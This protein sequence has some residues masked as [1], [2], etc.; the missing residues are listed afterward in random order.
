MLMPSLRRLARALADADAGVASS[1]HA[2]STILPSLEEDHL[3][4]LDDVVMA[5]EAAL[6]GGLQSM[7]AR[8]AALQSVSARSAVHVSPPTCEGA[9]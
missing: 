2:L 8:L 1:W 5:D 4:G 7:E 3:S 9:R 6:E